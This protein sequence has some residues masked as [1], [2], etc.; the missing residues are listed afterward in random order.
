MGPRQ[1]GPGWTPTDPAAARRKASLFRGQD[2]R[3]AL[4]RH[5]HYMRD[6]TLD[7]DRQAYDGR[8][9]LTLVLITLVHLSLLGVLLLV[10]LYHPDKKEENIVWVSPGSFGGEAAA[11]GIAS[12]ASSEPMPPAPEESTESHTPKMAE[13]PEASPAEP[14]PPNPELSAEP[15]LSP[16]DSELVVPTA[17]PFATPLPIPKPSQSPTPKPSA[18]PNPTPKATPRA[19]PKPTPR[20]TPKPSPKPAVSPRASASPGPS[21]KPGS[22]PK[23][24]AKEKPE[25]QP[26]PKPETSLKSKD[27]KSKSKVSPDPGGHA[28]DEEKEK[29]AKG[30][31]ANGG[32][33]ISGTAA[34][35]R[36]GGGTG[37]GSGDSALAAYVGILTS[38]FQAAWNQPTGEMAMGKTLEVTVRLRVEADG[39][40]TE[41]TIVEGSGNAVVDE[42]VR[43]A[44]KTITRLPPPPNNQAFSAPVRFELGN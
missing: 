19:T 11:W 15:A 41:F 4:R 23:E 37:S 8:F 5:H 2:T 34:P 36:R 35:G 10:S 26:S 14:A 13:L 17:T 3:R 29:S 44:G 18:T 40:V 39:K 33:G 28:A 43:Q 32:N 20:A 12:A 42:S 22:T 7:Y 1:G 16:T 30:Q 24:K 31:T 9:K 25:S 38:R 21:H 27:N 6:G